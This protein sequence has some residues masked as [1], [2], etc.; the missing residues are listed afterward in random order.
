MDIEYEH[1]LTEVE[2]RSKSN[3]HRITEIEKRQDDLD[4]LV[5]SVKVLAVREEAVEK[6]VKE[7]KTDVKNLANK[8]AQRWDS[9]VDKIFLTAVGL[10]IGYIFSKIG[11]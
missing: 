6:D 5:S 2:D 3:C 8:P 1:R 7:I 11:F 9:L 10:L 4:E